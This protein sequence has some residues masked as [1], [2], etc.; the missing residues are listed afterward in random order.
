V[1]MLKWDDILWDQK[2]MVVHAPKTKRY[3]KADRIIP[4]F[5]HIEECLRAARQRGTEGDGCS[6][7]PCMC[8]ER[9]HRL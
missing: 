3:G 8:G 4:F 2:E 5:P 1:M 6:R 7:S 9:E